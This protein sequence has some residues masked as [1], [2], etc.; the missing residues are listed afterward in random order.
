IYGG[1]AATGSAQ[2]HWNG[3]V[4][5]I[6]HVDRLLEIIVDVG[7][8]IVALITPG[9]QTALDLKPGTRVTVAVKATAVRIVPA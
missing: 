6:R 3:T 9:A 1:A 7:V 5:D 8:R 4:T 2:N